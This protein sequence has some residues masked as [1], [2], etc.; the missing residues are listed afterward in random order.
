M[1]T[2][3]TRTRHNVAL[4]V[5]CLSCSRLSAITARSIVC[6]YWPIC[7]LETFLSFQ[8]VFFYLSFCKAESLATV[9]L[10][11]H[12]CDTAQTDVTCETRFSK[13]IFKFCALLFTVTANSDLAKGPIVRMCTCRYLQILALNGQGLIRNQPINCIVMIYMIWYDIWYGIWYMICCIW[14][15]IIWYDMICDI[16]Y[17]IWYDMLYMI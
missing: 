3:V 2:T 9:K 15:D 5:H 17:D 6:V 4:Y 8:T 10:N 7:V 11:E 1:A 16:W 12:C 13:K 14:Y